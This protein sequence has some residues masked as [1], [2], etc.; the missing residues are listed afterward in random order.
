MY[1]I[2]LIKKFADVKDVKALSRIGV[3]AYMCVCVRVCVYVRGHPSHPSHPS[4]KE[5]RIIETKAYETFDKMRG[6]TS[7]L[8]AFTSFTSRGLA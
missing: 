8:I 4:H 3:C 7:G 2:D 5:K 1:V 6:F